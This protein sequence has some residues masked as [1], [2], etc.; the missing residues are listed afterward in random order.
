MN[1]IRIKVQYIIYIRTIMMTKI[2]NS[3]ISFK[4][5]K[6]LLQIKNINNNKAS[7]K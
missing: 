6:K 7:K 4:N 3:Q 5:K 1:Q 2:E